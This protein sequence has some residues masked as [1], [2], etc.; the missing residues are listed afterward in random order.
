MNK[1][2]CSIDECDEPSYARSWCRKHYSRWRRHGNPDTV[3]ISP[4]SFTPEQRLRRIG[5]VVTDSGCW[6]WQ[7]S[8]AV[9]G[10][11]VLGY[12]GNQVGAHRLAYET[13]VAPIPDGHVIR[14]KCDNPPCINPD[15]LLP[16]TTIDNSRDMV[17]R[18][19][20]FHAKLDWEKVRQIRDQYTGARG[21]QT[22]LAKKFNV[23]RATIGYVVR[24]DTWKESTNDQYPT[25]G[26]YPRP[27]NT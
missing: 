27:R 18:G 10:H 15:H 5:W 26:P 3:L 13:W 12:R 24:G 25:P 6:E 11:G 7:G 19:R 8:R 4:R 9:W 16:G 20:V 14:H 17:E 22:V 2:P 21:Q 23:D 1:T